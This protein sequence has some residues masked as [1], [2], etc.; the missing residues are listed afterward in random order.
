MS[1]VQASL[2]AVAVASVLTLKC[3]QGAPANPEAGNGQLT[4]DESALAGVRDGGPLDPQCL[5]GATPPSADAGAAAYNVSL[6]ETL[7]G[8]TNYR[9]SNDLTA[10]F[11]CLRFSGAHN[12][13]LDCAGHKISAATP[14]SIINVEG[15]EIKNCH[16]E[17]PTT[18]G[19]ILIQD[20]GTGFIHDNWLDGGSFS[21]T[22]AHNLHAYNNDMVG[23][24]QQN[25][26]INS[27]I[28]CNTMVSPTNTTSIV[29]LITSNY[30][31]NN[32]YQRNLLDGR[33]PSTQVPFAQVG[34][35]DG[36]SFQ[37]EHGSTVRGNNI[38]RCWDMGVESS[39]YIH[40][41]KVVYNVISDIGLAGFGAFYYASVSHSVFKLNKVKKTPIAFYFFHDYGLRP[42]SPNYPA[43]IAVYFDNNVFDGNTFA[44]NKPS[45]SPIIDARVFSKM[46]YGGN[47]SGIPGERVPLDSEFV[48]TN[49]VFRNNNLD[50]RAL[51]P[52]WSSNGTGSVPGV[53][54]DDGGNRCPTDPTGN[55][56]CLP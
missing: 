36:I 7:F 2:I 35:D 24:W 54:V 42:A 56:H 20:A 39:G 33:W 44:S 30:G 40:N 46:G 1:K 51:A 49:N 12:V 23:Y 21:V 3:G 27:S 48:I 11:T 52:F 34:A 8:A 26:V 55:L 13:T 6:C 16:F 5:G 31:A 10:T 22:G 25:G 47:L 4:T 29:A 37:D 9:L 41:F 45:V 53:I 15:F 19:E 50:P 38:S 14:V 17:M 43:D 28:S 32:V 18:S